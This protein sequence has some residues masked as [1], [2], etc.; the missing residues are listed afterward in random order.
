MKKGR[1]ECASFVLPLYFGDHRGLD[2]EEFS[3]FRIGL[4]W[5]GRIN[6]LNHQ[7]AALMDSKT[8]AFLKGAWITAFFTG[9][10]DVMIERHA[11]DNHLMLA[12]GLT[13][14]EAVERFRKTLRN[15]YG[16]RVMKKPDQKATS[17]FLSTVNP[18]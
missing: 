17:I 11:E 6:S 12:E 1:I 10:L 2:F 8:G 13:G 4:A 14:S 9:P 7:R 16:T 5:V 3:T 15:I 18:T